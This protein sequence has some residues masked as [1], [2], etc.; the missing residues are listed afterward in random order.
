MLKNITLSLLILA[1]LFGFA[2]MSTSAQN[3]TSGL[4]VQDKCDYARMLV[5][6]KWGN[7]L[8]TPQNTNKIS[9]DGEINVSQG[10][11]NLDKI[12]YFE[13]HDQQ[14]DRIISKHNPVSWTSWI[15]PKWDG[16][17]V[18]VSAS[19]EAN[20]TVQTDQG[21]LSLPIRKLLASRKPTVL[22]FNDG[23]EIVVKVNKILTNPFYLRVYWGGPAPKQVMPVQTADEPA[24]AAMTTQDLD[25]QLELVETEEIQPIYP[26]VD[27]SGAM[28]VGHGANMKLVKPLLF[29]EFQGDKILE[30]DPNYIAWNSFIRG[31]YDGLLAKARLDQINPKDDTLA[32]KFPEINWSKELSLFKLYQA[33]TAKYK[34]MFGGRA[35]NLIIQAVRKNICPI[36]TPAELTEA[37]AVLIEL[38]VNTE[39]AA[40]LQDAKP[41]VARQA[42]VK[43]DK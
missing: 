36:I 21:G 19:P 42:T 1:L 25:Q 33:G 13:H 7:V 41:A 30:A 11:V 28:A 27:F 24:V 20:F 23:R 43:L 35:Y 22:Q 3:Q 6:V 15:L 5:T 40:D 2:P 4:A 8:G 9:F 17:R 10:S 31:H 38:P 18:K 37:E 12:L 29:E 39:P 26:L 34:I 16:V 32:I 14:K